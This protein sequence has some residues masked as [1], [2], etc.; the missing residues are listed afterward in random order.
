[1]QPRLHSI[2][3]KFS[4]V[5]FAHWDWFKNKVDAQHEAHELR[6]KGYKVHITK[7]K[8]ADG[9]YYAIWKYPVVSIELH[10]D[11]ESRAKLNLAKMVERHSGTAFSGVY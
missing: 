9:T 10:R 5:E 7:Q 8:G 6:E 2:Y 3:K 1:M 4:G 11:L